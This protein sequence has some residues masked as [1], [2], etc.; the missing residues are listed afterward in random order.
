MA[1]REDDA[2]P[3]R[4]GWWTRRFTQARMRAYLRHALTTIHSDTAG[5]VGLDFEPGSEE[6]LTAAESWLAE[7][8]ASLAEPVAP[9]EPGIVP[10]LAIAILVVG[11]RGDVQPFLPIA[12][13][14]Q[15]A[16]HRVRVAT[17]EEFRSLVQA[18]GVEFF[19]LAADPR[20]L[21][22]YMV[23][24]GG[25]I[26]P[27]KLEQFRDDVP[28]KRELVAEIIESTWQA[29]IAPDPAGGN[30][31]AFRAD[32]IL[33]NPP[34][35]GHI[36]LA[37]ALRVPLHMVFTMPWTPTTAFPHPLANLGGGRHGPVENWLS[38]LTIDFLTWAGSADLVNRFREETLGLEPILLGEGGSSLVHDN[39]VPTTYLWSPSF[40]PKPADWGDTVEVAG[41]AF[42][43]Q[44]SS[45]DP[46]RELT[47]FLEQGP[48]PFYIGFG[49]CVIDDPAAMTA[50]LAA[51]VQ[52]AGVRA[53][54]SR[55]WAG[56]GEGL[57]DPAILVV[58]D[59]PH[60]WLLPH[61]AGICHHG[62]AGTVAA[63]LRAGL[64]T[65]VVPFFGDQYFWGDAVAR[66]GAGP[67]PLPG[68]R[69]DADALAEAIA[70]CGKAETRQRARAISRSI[71]AEDGA[72]AA[73][74]AFHRHLP[75]DAMRCALD[76]HHLAR[77]FCEDCELPLCDLCDALVHDD[78]AR[79][80]HDRVV[81]HWIDW[82]IRPP[83]NLVEGLEQGIGHAVGELFRSARDAFR[84]PV[85]GARS[86]GARGLARGLGDA[87]EALVAGP[88]R[89]GLSLARRIAA[90]VE[91]Q[92]E[93]MAGDASG[94][95][96]ARAAAALSDEERA[97]L[98]G[99]YK[100][101]MAE[102]GLRTD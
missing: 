33:A 31:T 78:A 22:A 98:L 7:H 102:A 15:A 36:H 72:S 21:I 86:D 28:R 66:A 9:A 43:D 80:G 48:A 90:A 68:A 75:L 39:E 101:R 52:R 88:V 77:H 40:V 92:D 71:A 85:R 64:P 50:T 81:W 70:F 5:R 12:R 67:A 25:H 53:I 47:D 79:R 26:L 29:C 99:R 17:H 14:L 41:F 23:R 97:R 6:S 73:V 8:R 1:E 76:E 56:L 16:G 96:A 34:C 94:P 11:T 4:A 83:E 44:A 46:P 59:V 51:A 69:L 3:K 58:G 30:A 10:P 87:A 61:L 18:S 24:T 27:T 82:G 95:T 93:A 49:S 37:E 42:L 62:G 20:E 13:E 89:G 19:P 84:E 60:D 55:G 63:G 32:A 35:F 57:D 2:T 91:P 100:E 74:A 65:I 54:L 45:Y 38:F